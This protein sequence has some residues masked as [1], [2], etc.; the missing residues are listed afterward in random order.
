MNDPSQA[1][2]E[3]MV[4]ASR[5]ALYA[6][7]WLTDGHVEDVV[8]EALAALLSQRKCPDDPVAWMYAAVRNGAIDR[9][10]AG[11]RRRKRE[12]RVASERREW[13]DD[14]VESALDAQTAQAALEKLPREL[15]E[16]VV[17]RI[18]G[19]LGFVEIARIAQVSVGTAHQRFGEALKQMRTLL[20]V[21]K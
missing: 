4:H 15:R 17:L 10:R 3:V 2:K 6:R 16:I 1:A 21:N 13:F 20:H 5:L 11:A 18:W 8:Q 9:L 12:E 14:S 7:Q 19:G